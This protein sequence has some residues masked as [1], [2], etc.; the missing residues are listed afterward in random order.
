MTKNN[1]IIP[2]PNSCEIDKYLDKWDSMENYILQENSLTKLFQKTYPENTDMDDVLIKVCSLNDFYSTNIF[3]S[4]NVAK[5]IVLLGVDDRLKRNDI[6]LVNDIALIKMKDKDRNFY[7]FA[8][9]YCSHHKPIEYPMYD[10]YV[11]KILKYF[12]KKDAFCQFKSEDLK[13][14]YRFKEILICFQNN[15]SLQKYSLKDIDRYLWQLGKD[16]FLK[17]Y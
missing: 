9:K 3:S 10:Y 5:H 11:D 12:N 2:T 4:F 14:Y 8:T 13:Q 15:Y 6:S 7:S 17:K 1:I 16:C